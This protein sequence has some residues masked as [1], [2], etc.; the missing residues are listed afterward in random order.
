MNP[1]II[2]VVVII[3]CLAGAFA[4]LAGR[5]SRTEGV[6]PSKSTRWW[7]LALCSAVCAVAV[8]VFIL[9]LYVRS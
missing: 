5:Q 9:F 2:A 4:A 6:G 8:A 1:G 7:I 3:L